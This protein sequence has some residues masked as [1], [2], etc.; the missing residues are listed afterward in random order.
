MFQGQNR[1]VDEYD[2]EDDYGS[3]DN[4]DSESDNGYGNEM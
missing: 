3:E 4:S 2:D 1:F